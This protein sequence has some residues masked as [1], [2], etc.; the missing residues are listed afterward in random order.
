MRGARS[1]TRS[2]PPELPRLEAGSGQARRGIVRH[3]AADPDRLLDGAER[4]GRRSQGDRGRSRPGTTLYDAIVRASNTLASEPLEARVIIVVTDGNETRSSASLNEA[5]AAARKARTAIYVVAIE[6]PKFNP[7]APQARRADGRRVPR[8]LVERDPERR[9]RRRSRPSS[10]ARGGSTTRPRSARGH[11][12]SSRRP[13]KA[14]SR[15]RPARAPA[16]L[17]P[18]SDAEAL[19]PAARVFYKTVLGTQVMALV[20]FFIVLIAAS[21]ALT[22]VKGARLKKRLAPH[23]AK[24]PR[25][26][27]GSRR[28]NGSRP[29]PGSSGRPRAHSRTGSSGSGSIGWSSEATCRSERSSSST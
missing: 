22:T 23:I 17:G 18:G 4:P 25:R 1:Q 13:G 2:R 15:S 24:E 16:S 20:S 8:H 9:V 7:P 5:I 14:R 12:A 10:A 26:R 11:R 3:Q 28:R 19:A 29:R 21:L 27:S 6:S